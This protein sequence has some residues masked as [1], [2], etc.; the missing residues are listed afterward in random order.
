MAY[1]KKE[2]YDDALKAIHEHHLFFVSDVLAY[3]PCSKQTFYDFFPPE[4]D[5]LDNIKRK[6]NDNKITTKVEIRG[7]LLKGEK[8]AEL[9]ALY[10]LIGTEE[11]RQA[12]SQ[13]YQKIEGDLKTNKTYELTDEQLADVINALKPGN[14]G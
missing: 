8:A 6:L 9:L 12:L 14:E 3:I 11:E 10:K 7:K 4:S 5:K 2:I 13:T 1:D